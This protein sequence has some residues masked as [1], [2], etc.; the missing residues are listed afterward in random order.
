MD[1]YIKQR[2]FTWGDKFDVCDVTGQPRYYVEGEVFSWGKKLHVYDRY[3]REV[4][5]I[6]QELFTF[7]PRYQ[8][9]VS[10]SQVAA[11]C[12]EFT[13]LKPRY[14][15]EGPNWEVEGQFWLHDYDVTENGRPV[16]SIQKEWLTWGDTYRLQIAPGADEIL[17]LAVVLT[18]ECVIAQQDND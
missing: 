9:W 2:I 7:L 12:K 13:F 3:D 15:V 17:A 10:G 4:A 6:C 5:Y 18:I 16:V 14:R 8:V 1:L 11:V